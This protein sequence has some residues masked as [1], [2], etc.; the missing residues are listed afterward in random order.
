M[1]EEDFRTGVVWSRMSRLLSLRGLRGQQLGTVGW[2]AVNLSTGR[3]EAVELR[4]TWQTLTIP[5]H[6]VTLNGDDADL[7]L[8]AENESAGSQKSSD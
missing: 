1:S 8:L 7:R 5:W 2:C 6:R 3:I 4:T